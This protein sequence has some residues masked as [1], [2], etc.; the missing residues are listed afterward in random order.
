[1]RLRPQGRALGRGRRSTSGLSRLA[2][3]LGIALFVVEASVAVAIIE[4]NSGNEIPWTTIALAVT[5]GAA[6]VLSGLIALTL[7]PDNRTGLYLAATGYVWFLSALSDSDNAWVF[8]VGFVLGNVV[9]VPFTA[10]VLAYPTGRLETRLERAIPLVTGAVLVVPALLAALLDSSP[11]Q[12]CDSCPDSSIALADQGGIGTGLDVVATVGGLVLIAVV[13]GALARRWRRASP[14]LRRLAWPVLGAGIAALLSIG[15]VI[16]A[17]R[18]SES[19]R[20]ALQ[21]LFF[22]AFSAVPVAFLF[23]VLR[24]RLAR[25]SVSEVVVALEAGTPLR[26][27]IARALNDPSLEVVYRLDTGDWID[28][29]GRR[30]PDPAESA[31]RKVTTVTRDGQPVAALIHDA[32]L[33][34]EPE[35]I[36]AITAAAGLSLHNER[37]QAELRAQV[38][39]METI[40]RTTPSLLTHVG[41]DGRIQALN[42]AT[43]KASGY[44]EEDEVRGK[45]FWDVFIDESEREAMKA[46]FAA[47]A[48]DYAAAEYE[49]T[50]TNARGEQL[51]IYWRNAPVVDEQG[52]V[53]S[54]V[55]GGLDVTERRRR[56]LELRR[57]RDATATVLEAIPS[58]VV[59]VDRDGTIRDRDVD[60][61]RAGANSA[62]RQALGWRDEELVG[63]SFLDLIVEDAD[64]RAAA[65]LTTAAE[66]SASAEVESEL[67]C[68]DGS[69][70][71]FA[72]SAVP[73]AD[74]TGR[75]EALVLVSGV[76]V[77]ERKGFEDEIRASRA[78]LV[79]AEDEA[80]RELERNLHDG[81]QQR[82]VALS[83]ALR[84][85]ESKLETEPGSASTLLGSARDE[86]AQALEEL[87]ELARGIH[88]AVLTD[89]GL[90]PALEA[91]AGRAPIPVELVAP[92]GRMSPEVEAAAYYVVAESLTNVAK[93][94]RASSAN[95]RVVREDGV[96]AV[97]IADNGVG[98]AD[99][100]RGTGLRGLVDRVAVL[101]GSLSVESPVGGGTLIRAEIPFSGT[102][103]EE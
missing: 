60:N 23:G 63:R 84:L 87:R 77:T 55:S 16:V 70:R 82:L 44:S 86:L 94:A 41:T 8:T 89:R 26:D 10:L 28:P 20:D 103:D 36:D 38:D 78:R 62:F 69:I 1:M 53:A 52:R 24:T 100:T 48:P 83:V 12:N 50:F 33:A 71:A 81:A 40:T 15:L 73:V 96:L 43:L 57:E 102:T 90:R 101:D 93:Y 9:W 76:D 13:V 79:R 7:R 17:D 49:N 75:T 99:L 59:V 32:S 91:L 35:L 61:P 85:V 25:S 4:S 6:F 68:A 21:V 56:E 2:L 14:A 74:V 95:V 66:G 5:A 88:P 34:E 67:R 80:R 27:A 65:A 51:V 39:L 97:T 31:G 18:I 11:A 47:A 37:L 58:I 42:L 22:L 29:S 64:G 30:V 72:W 54:I 3:A 92:A 45:Y 46:R 98:G 19:A